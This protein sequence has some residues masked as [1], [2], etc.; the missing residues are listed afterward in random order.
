MSNINFQNIAASEINSYTVGHDLE[1][2]DTAKRHAIKINNIIAEQNTYEKNNIFKSRQLISQPVKTLAI[3]CNEYVPSHFSNGTYFKYV[4]TI[5]GI[6]YEITP[7]NSHRNGKKI[8][9]TTDYNSP[10]EHVIYINEEIKSAFLSIVITAP[11]TTESP[12]ISNLKVL[13]GGG[14]NV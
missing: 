9:R 6:D 10:S 2:L 3:F 4:M 11:N 7:I 13:A 14:V 5:N 8:I 1:I 12:F